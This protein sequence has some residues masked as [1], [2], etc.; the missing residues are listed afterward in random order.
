[1]ARP[2]LWYRHTAPE[3]PPDSKLQKSRGI[4]AIDTAPPIRGVDFRISPVTHQMYQ[5]PMGRIPLSNFWVRIPPPSPAVR[6]DVRI[7]AYTWVLP[8]LMSSFDRNVDS[9]RSRE[10]ASHCAISHGPILNPVPVTGRSD[11][12]QRPDPVIGSALELELSTD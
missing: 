4:L 1:M 2:Y 6:N 5:D 8:S 12:V 9:R 3:S 10:T 11:A 7:P